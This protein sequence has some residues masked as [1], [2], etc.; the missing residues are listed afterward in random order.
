MAKVG[1]RPGKQDTRADIVAA[2]RASFA[3]HG[4]ERSSM[5]AIARRAGV[6]AALVHHYF[7]SKPALFVEAL[8]MRADPRTIAEEIHAEHHNLGA[9]AELVRAFVGIWDG[10]AA[11]DA[12][13]P[14]G[15]GKTSPF[16]SV[17]Q[18]VAAS[19]QAADGLREFLTDRI[20]NYVSRD[21]DPEEAALRHSL[22]ASQLFGLGWTRYV[23]RLEPFASASIEQLAAWVGPTLD[24]H[25]QRTSVK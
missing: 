17:V 4:Y 19:P 21:A 10:P 13:D 22:I 5:R 18:A 2:A 11:D 16:V 3:E 24:G 25:L 8:F 7:E 1:R 12:D 23:L 15:A 9:G 6:D 14:D 20:W